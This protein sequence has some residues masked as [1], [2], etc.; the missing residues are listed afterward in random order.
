MARVFRNGLHRV[1]ITEHQKGIANTQTAVNAMKH[2]S[3]EQRL[4]RAAVEGLLA[5]KGSAFGLGLLVTNTAF[6]RDAIW[7][8]QKSGNEAFVRLRDF[9]DLRRWLQG[10]FGDDRD[11]R[12]IPDQIKPA[13]SIVIDVPKPRVA[14]APEIWPVQELDFEDE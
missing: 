5:W 7:A 13:P 11:W 14:N 4:G 10:N 8:A 12:E 2:H 9:E 1:G 3:G 6:T